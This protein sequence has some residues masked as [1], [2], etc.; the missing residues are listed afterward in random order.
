MRLLHALALAVC[1]SAMDAQAAPP[2]P[3][4]IREAIGR[5]VAFLE[6]EQLPYGEFPVDCQWLKRWYPADG[7]PFGTGTILYSLRVVEDRRVSAM[8]EKAIAFLLQEMESP[9][10][11]RYWSMRN[12]SYDKRV[13]PD[14]DDTSVIGLALLAR[15][16]PFPRDLDFLLHFRTPEKLFVTWMVSMKNLPLLEEMEKSEPMKTLSKYYPD[17]KPDCVVNA[18]VLAYFSHQGQTLPEVCD[19][20]MEII[21]QGTDPTAHS[22]YHHLSPYPFAYAVSKA[23]RE[24]AVCLKPAVDPLT[25]L[26]V[27]RQQEDGSWGNTLETALAT[28]A[29]LNVGYQGRAI[30]SAIAYL[31][32][33]QGS[34]GGWSREIYYSSVKQPIAYGSQALT[35][36]FV[37][38]ALGKYLAKR[39][40]GQ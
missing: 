29:L 40:T 30:D 32:T 7:T 5:G 12:P 14:F 25:A 11:W 10:L 24:G 9:G 13:V 35:T 17:N 8:E 4:E 2:A 31:L 36:G 33:R 37:L 38:E 34:H 21:R 3:R 15:A 6:H 23:Y 19:Y 16:V 26:L 39:A 20:L 22:I 1:A 28:N 18:Q 27:T